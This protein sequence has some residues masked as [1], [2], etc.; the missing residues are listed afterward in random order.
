MKNNTTI[1]I[2]V[3]LNKFLCIYLHQF[4]KITAKVKIKISNQIQK[5]LASFSLF[6]LAVIM[7]VSFFVHFLRYNFS[8]A[9][10]AKNQSLISRETF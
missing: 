8:K 5:T 6:I 2:N 10:I 9:V 1:N 3:S 7:F 4:Y